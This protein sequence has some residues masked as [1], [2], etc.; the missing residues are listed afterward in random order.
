MRRNGGGEEP[1]RADII[2]AIDLPVEGVYLAA[3]AGHRGHN[4]IARITLIVVGHPRV[5]IARL[6][7]HLPRTAQVV[8]RQHAS[9]GML[10]LAVIELGSLTVVGGEHRQ[11]AVGV[12]VPR[13]QTE[14]LAAIGVIV[15]LLQDMQILERA[16][17]VALNGVVLADDSVIIVVDILL[18]IVVA[19]L[20]FVGRR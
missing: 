1:L 3:R 17:A 12:Y 7:R 15:G 13:T 14:T 9:E 6:G 4:A 10:T 8:P 18:L 11:L 5:D 20:I 16:T 19:V 2:L